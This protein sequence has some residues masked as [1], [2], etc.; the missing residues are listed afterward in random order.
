MAAVRRELRE[1]RSVFESASASASTSA[2]K[3]RREHT[4]THVREVQQPSQPHKKTTATLTVDCETQSRETTE[5]NG[6]RDV[7][8]QVRWIRDEGSEPR[9]S[10]TVLHAWYEC[11]L[12]EGSCGLF[13]LTGSLRALLRCRR[14]VESTR[15]RCVTGA[16]SNDDNNGYLHWLRTKFVYFPSPRPPDP[17]EA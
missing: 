12:D 10:G 17:G 14:E 7:R 5:G 15:K 16:D 13:A 1:T 4:R 8:K 6:G 3:G 11:A 9:V 2:S